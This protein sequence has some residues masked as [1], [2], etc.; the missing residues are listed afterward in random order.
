MSD[1]LPEAGFGMLHATANV[2]KL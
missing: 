2:F 1:G